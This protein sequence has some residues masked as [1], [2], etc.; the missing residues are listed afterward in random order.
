LHLKLSEGWRVKIPITGG[1]RSA[2][3]DT[4]VEGFVVGKSG[5]C[6]GFKTIDLDLDKMI[7]NKYCCGGGCGGMGGFGGCF[8]VYLVYN[9]SKIFL[10]AILL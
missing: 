5:F 4:P 1:S 2:K 3:R 7:Y 6:L 8:N 10:V 9:P